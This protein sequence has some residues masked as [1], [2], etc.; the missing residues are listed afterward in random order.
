MITGKVGCKNWV[1]HSSDLQGESKKDIEFTNF[2]CVE[3][4]LTQFHLL[5]SNYEVGLLSLWVLTTTTGEF[6]RAEAAGWGGGAGLGS[7]Q[8]T[9][10]SLRI[11]PGTPDILSKVPPSFPSRQMSGQYISHQATTDCYT[12]ATFHFINQQHRQRTCFGF[13]NNFCLQLVSF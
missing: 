13:L 3:H 11:S 2:I 6:Q 4:P 1:N 12:H 9:G 10:S 8:R 5:S 7:C